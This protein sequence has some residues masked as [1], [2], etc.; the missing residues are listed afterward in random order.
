M[1]CLTIRLTKTVIEQVNELKDLDL[2]S[3]KCQKGEILI[4]GAVYDLFT[5]KVKFIPETPATLP[6]MKNL[7]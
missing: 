1:I 3:K 4:A 6:E 2:V 5:G 7:K